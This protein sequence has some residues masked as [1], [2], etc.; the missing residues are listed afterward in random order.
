MQTNKIPDQNTNGRNE[1]NAR[2][3]VAYFNFIPLFF[4]NV[5]LKF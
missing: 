1:R 5:T 4:F 3:P 2:K